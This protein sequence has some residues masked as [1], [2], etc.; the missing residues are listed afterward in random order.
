LVC[1]Q[2]SCFPPTCCCPRFSAVIYCFLATGNV[3][4]AAI[5]G[6]DGSI[7]ACSEGFTVDPAKASQLWNCFA[8]AAPLRNGGLMINGDKYTFIRG[9][10]RKLYLKK[11]L[12][13]TFIVRTNRAIIIGVHN[14]S[15]VPEPASV[16]VDKLADYL[17]A[18]NF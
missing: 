14:E 16:T 1:T 13:G 11:G 8:D 6:A 10:D 2:R 3:A 15:Q 18:S 9:D 4:S 12:N 17:T 7:W 5:L